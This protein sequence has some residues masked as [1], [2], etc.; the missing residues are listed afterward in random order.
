M[1]AGIM[2]KAIGGTLEGGEALKRHLKQIEQQLGSGAH[3]VVGFLDSATYPAKHVEAT[4]ERFLSGKPKR[5]DV[6]G[7]GQQDFENSYGS[8]AGLPVAQVAF[9]NE[10]GTIKTPARPFFRTMVESKSPRWGIALGNAL[11]K[12][13]YNGRAALAIMGEGIRGQLR[14]SIRDWSTPPNS[15]RTVALKGFNK[16]LI[17]SAVMIRSAE[18]QV[19]DG[20]VGGD[21][22]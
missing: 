8:G 3:V 11:R 22:D 19:L 6:S 13:N 18:Y 16:P 15:P 10:F 5:I 21:D 14:Q 17:D 2:Q 7:K 12:T 9:W 20:D 1:P 4:R